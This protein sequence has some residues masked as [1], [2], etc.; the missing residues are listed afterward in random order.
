MLSTL[1]ARANKPRSSPRSRVDAKKRKTMS[2]NTTSTNKTL[3]LLHTLK[4]EMPEIWGEAQIVGKWVWLEFNIPPEREIRARLKELGFH[5]NGPRKCW[6]HPCGVSRPRLKGDPRSY[7]EVKPASALA[8]NDALIAKEYKV[9][10][11]RECPLPESLLRCETPDNAAEYWRL[12]VATNPYF[13]P[14][15]ECFVVLLLNTRRRVKGHQLVTIGTMDTLLIHPREVFR[16]A[17]ISSAAAV[18]LMHNHPSGDPTP[19]EADIKVT[20]DLIR[21]GQL[22]KIEVLD[23]VIIGTPNRSSLRELGYFYN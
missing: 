16:V 4:T 23:H 17:V 9:V 22:M 12:H 1:P 15:C 2:A 10:A 7:Y 13:N 3:A 11:L 14:E 6:Q 20:R 18:V 8:M 19:S 5:W 21:A